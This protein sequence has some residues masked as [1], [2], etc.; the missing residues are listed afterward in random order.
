MNKFEYRNI[1]ITDFL[2][3]KNHLPVSKKGANW[4]YLSP[5]HNERTASFKVNIDKNVWYDFGLGKGGGLVTL[6][7]LLYHPNSFQDY[8]HLF[9]GIRASFPT[10]QEE[11]SKEPSTF[12][13]IE[14]MNLVNPALFTYLAKRGITQQVASQYCKE[15]H[16]LSQGKS[17][18]AIGFPNCSG[19]YEIRNAY[20]KG[21]ISPKDISVISQ[22]NKECHVFEGFVDFLSYVVLHE[23]CD[24]VILNSVINVPKSIGILNNY[25]S[26]FCHLDNDKAGRNATNQ[27]MALCKSEVTDA[28]DEYA[29]A[30]DLNEF[31]CKRMDNE[32][33]TYKSRGLRR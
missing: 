25:R 9:D 17:Y 8:V 27:I 18:F 20:F 11:R 2:A 26:V 10:I 30:K 21:C 19:G 13:N 5:L 33:Y 6:V 16:Y 29:D 14:A 1:Q 23:G 24:A 7:N 15:I 3:E 4:W 31:L 28:S 12:C 32:V 22:G